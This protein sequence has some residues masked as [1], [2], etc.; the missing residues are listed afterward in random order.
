MEN[1]VYEETVTQHY[2]N[3]VSGL[4]KYRSALETL[5]RLN[6]ERIT[7][8]N[9]YSPEMLISLRHEQVYHLQIDLLIRQ[10]SKLLREGNLMNKRVIAPDRSMLLFSALDV[11]DAR[12]K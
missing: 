10:I 12:M 11:D 1:K 3:L 6:Q 5:Q 2:Q 9:K 8:A 4:S 7:I